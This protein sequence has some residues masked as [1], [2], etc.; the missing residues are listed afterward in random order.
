MGNTYYY[1]ADGSQVYG[2]QTINGQRQY[3]D[4]HTGAQFR[5]CTAV[6]D[7]KKYTFDLNGDIVG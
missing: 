6:I 3:F 2:W 1:G 7:G 4:P 5:N